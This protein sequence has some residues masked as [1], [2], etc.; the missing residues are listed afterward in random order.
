M[1]ILDTDLI[2]SYFRKLPKA[3]EV[4]NNLKQSNAEI[5][6]TIINIGEL[7]KGA[8][9]SSKVDENI[10]QI[11]KF[12]KNID[13]LFFEIEDIKTYAQISAELRKKGEAIGD[14]DE[15]IA[16]IVINRN[17]T[18][19]TRNI[20]HYERISQISLKNWEKI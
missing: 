5:K 13:I 18:L 16:C 17:E 20:R 11:E 4:I 6:T 9:L 1:P 2:I 19:F 3:I 8:F 10:R 7:Y 15:L 14:F 12:L